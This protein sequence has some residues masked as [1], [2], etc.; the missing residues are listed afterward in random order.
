M[1]NNNSIISYFAFFKLILIVQIDK[2]TSSTIYFKTNEKFN[3]DCIFFS[4]F[5]KC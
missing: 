4:H 1:I 3:I 2:L 5:L